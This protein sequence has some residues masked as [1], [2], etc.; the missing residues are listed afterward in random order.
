[1]VEPPIENRVVL[2]HHFCC[3]KAAHHFRAT[4]DK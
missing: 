4:C 2:A 1:M 3:T